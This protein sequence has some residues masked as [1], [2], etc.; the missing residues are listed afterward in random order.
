MPGLAWYQTANSAHSAYAFSLVP[1]DFTCSFDRTVLCISQHDVPSQLSLS[2][3]PV[4]RHL[5][6]FSVSLLSVAA[7]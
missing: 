1:E 5:I 7:L 3:L 4:S 6:S 2:M